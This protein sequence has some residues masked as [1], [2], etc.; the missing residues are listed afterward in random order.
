MRCSKKIYYIFYCFFVSQFITFL[1]LDVMM[2]PAPSTTEG[3]A[4]IIFFGRFIKCYWDNQ[5]INLL[6][7]ISAIE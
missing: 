2:T 5:R 4:M 7:R 6:A 1:T 3:E